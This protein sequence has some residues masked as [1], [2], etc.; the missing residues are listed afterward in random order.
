M[1]RKGLTYGTETNFQNVPNIKPAFEW[2]NFKKGQHGIPNV[3]K[4]E[5][6]WIGPG[7]E[8]VL[9]TTTV[10]DCGYRRGKKPI[11]NISF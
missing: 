10:S 1:G 5:A 6:S 11:A 8:G 9:G 4:V 3:V 7:G 2:K